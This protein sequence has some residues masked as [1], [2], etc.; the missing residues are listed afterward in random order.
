[1][2]RVQEALD[3]G[4][5]PMYCKNKIYCGVEEMSFEEIRAARWRNK[6]K[7][8]EESRRIEEERREMQGGSGR[9][10]KNFFVK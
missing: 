1:M 7:K 6:R 9:M 4:L 3:P 2:M 8:E 10:H 5:C